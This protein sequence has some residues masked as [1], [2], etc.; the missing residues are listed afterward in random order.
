MLF[1]NSAVKVPVVR[2]FEPPVAAPMPRSTPRHRTLG[3]QEADYQLLSLSTL[4]GAQVAF[5]AWTRLED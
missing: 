1:T 4:K 2:S 3:E 5:R